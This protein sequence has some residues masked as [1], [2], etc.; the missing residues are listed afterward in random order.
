M[1][2]KS[3]LFLYLLAVSVN[4]Q[5]ADSLF[6]EY[7]QHHTNGKT[8]TVNSIQGIEYGNKCGFNISNTIRE[9]FNAFSPNQQAVLSTMLERPERETSIVS[10]EGLFRIHYD[11]TGI[12][13]PD[14]FDIPGLSDAESC[15]KP[16]PRPS[17]SEPAATVWTTA[18]DVALFACKPVLCSGSVALKDTL[19]TTIA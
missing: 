19:S 16:L 1:R 10:P 11:L 18:S 9:H 3:L 8:K 17:A 15:D 5:N 12:H 7:I 2:I 13:R 14:Y 4:A 6:N